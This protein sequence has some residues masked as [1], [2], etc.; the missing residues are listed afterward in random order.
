MV[1]PLGEFTNAPSASQSPNVCTD[2]EYET[3]HSLPLPLPSVC[4]IMLIVK[5]TL[6]CMANKAT[7]ASSI[8]LM[9]VSLADCSSGVEAGIIGGGVGRGGLGI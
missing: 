5:L 6:G 9:A 2:P 3:F 7:S 4:V 1:S 8:I